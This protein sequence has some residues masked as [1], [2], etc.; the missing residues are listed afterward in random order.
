[1]ETV[2]QIFGMCFVGLI[3]ICIGWTIV[4]YIFTSINTPG[5]QNK[6][7]LDNMK[8]FDKNGRRI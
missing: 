3:M 1:M 4:E 5:N 6:K 2:I 7:L 8:K